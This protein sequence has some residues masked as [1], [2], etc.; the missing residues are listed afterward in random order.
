MVGVVKKVGVVT[1]KNFARFACERTPLLD[2]LDPPLEG[3]GGKGER[4]EN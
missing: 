4:G 2:I 3:G 1:P